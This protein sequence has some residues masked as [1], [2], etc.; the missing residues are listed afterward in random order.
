MSNINMFEVVNSADVKEAVLVIY[1]EYCALEKKG[2][3][4]PGSTKFV[5]GLYAKLLKFHLA[6]KSFGDNPT[7]MT[8]VNIAREYKTNG[9]VVRGHLMSL[10]DDL[11]RRF[12]K[13]GLMEAPK[14]YW[15]TSK[16]S[17]V[18]CPWVK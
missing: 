13:L 11:H 12:V 3:R 5:Y 9:T 7:P 8:I 16:T 2:K 17:L 4:L 15:S 6:Y 1:M 18:K 14:P 10:M